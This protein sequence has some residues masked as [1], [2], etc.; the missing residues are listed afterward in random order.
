MGA[1]KVIQVGLGPMGR[2]VTRFMA[3]RAGVEVVAAVDSDPR[4]IGSDLG[5]L[6]GLEPNGVRVAGSVD[7]ALADA[8]PQAALATTVSSLEKIAPLIETLTANKLAVVSTCEELVY[9]WKTRPGLAQRIDRAARAGGVAVLGTGVNPGFL[10]DALPVF[11]TAVCQ[12][13]RRVTV[14]RRQDASFRRI[15]FQK[16]IGAGLDLEEFEARKADGSLR[17]VGLTESMHLI[18]ACLGWELTETQ[19]LI[20]PVIAKRDIVAENLTVPAGRAAGVEQIG[21]G[22][23][24]AEE[25]ITLIFRA[26]VGEPDPLDAV[27]I[28]GDPPIASVIKGGVNGDTATAAIAI[29]ALRPVLEA[30][31]GLRTMADLPPAS[32]F[33]R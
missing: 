30:E 24:G 5:R 26:A 6:C 9:P 31:P 18:A 14:T 12:E 10:M 20:S 27:E 33:S 2:K 29:N 23:V 8:S 21:R 22:L 17:H 25:K 13:V 3:P 1:I 16:K 7:Q 15:P 32:F 4:V 19:D 28:E 11:L